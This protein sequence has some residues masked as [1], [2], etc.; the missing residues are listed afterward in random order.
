MEKNFYLQLTFSREKKINQRNTLLL[1]L[2]FARICWAF[3][4]GL[5]KKINII[6]YLNAQMF[7]IE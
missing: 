4:L 1:L 2:N 5:L 7:P 6:V 3:K